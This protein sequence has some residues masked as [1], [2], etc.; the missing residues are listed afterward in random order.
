MEEITKKRPKK[1]SKYKNKTNKKTQAGLP[2][3][4]TKINE[5]YKNV[6]K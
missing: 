4:V 2:K 3:G 6:D 1:M 5:L